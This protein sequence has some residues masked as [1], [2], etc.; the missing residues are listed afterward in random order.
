MCVGHFFVQIEIADHIF[1]NT[2]M[3]VECFFLFLVN[4]LVMVVLGIGYLPNFTASLFCYYLNRR[5]V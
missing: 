5:C 1:S 3:S 4:M 2:F